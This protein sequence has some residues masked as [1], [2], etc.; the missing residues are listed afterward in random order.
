M[1]F[2]GGPLTRELMRD[3][4]Y[5]ER[6]RLDRSRQ[7]IGS[8]CSGA[9]L[10]GALGLLEGKRATTYPTAVALLRA[11]GVDVV[12]E[13]FVQQGNVATAAACPAGQDLAGWVIEPLLG[14]DVRRSVLAEVQPVSRAM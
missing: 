11:L 9:L 6:F 4:A 2:G 14:A 7:L 13:S 10:L 3:A 8:M 12:D 5:L 1:L